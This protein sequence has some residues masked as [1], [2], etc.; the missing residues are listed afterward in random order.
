MER[1]GPPDKKILL[2]EARSIKHKG[3][4][5]S[6]DLLASNLLQLSCVSSVECDGGRSSAARACGMH[7]VICSRV[8]DASSPSRRTMQSP[9]N[10]ER[11][12]S[13]TWQVNI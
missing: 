3:D 2:R 7:S 13:K 9:N 12:T 1:R 11:T 10:G 8:T 6:K 5:Q 4:T